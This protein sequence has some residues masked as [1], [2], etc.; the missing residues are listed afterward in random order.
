MVVF[1][2][3]KRLYM[4]IIAVR[5]EICPIMDRITSGHIVQLN[6]GTPNVLRVGFHKEPKA[7]GV[8]ELAFVA[9]Q[10]RHLGFFHFSDTPFGVG[11]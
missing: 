2:I 6:R 11:M 4:R 7:F 5:I 1:E 8:N 9:N 3:L 10:R